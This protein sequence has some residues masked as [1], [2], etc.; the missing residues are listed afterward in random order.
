[1]RARL[2]GLGVATL[3]GVTV[4][5]RFDVAVVSG[6]E[7]APSILPGDVLILDHSAPTH[8]DVV[9]LT[10]PA[11][12]DRRVLRRVLA[13]PG[14]SGGLDGPQVSLQGE[15]VRRREME[16]T[17]ARV[18]TNEADRWLVQHRPREHSEPDRTFD[19]PDGHVWLMA[20]AR[21]DAIDSRWWG[22]V[23][24]ASLHGRVALRVGSSDA[25]RAP[26][27]VASVDGPWIP[28]SRMPQD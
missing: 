18:V 26:V 5:W 21:D 25:W 3:V 16:R 19:V 24:I 27:T 9:S 20:D 7:M 11:D 12:P 10:D 2:A 6:D 13:L 14:E 1:M 22:P 4:L 8:G 23:P 28:P 17:E 15:G